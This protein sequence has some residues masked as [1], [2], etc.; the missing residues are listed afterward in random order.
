MVAA[1]RHDGNAG[2]KNLC[3][4]GRARM[5]EGYVNCDFYTCLAIPSNQLHFSPREKVRSFNVI[6]PPFLFL[7]A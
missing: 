3:E 5:K 6:L 2:V 4:N 1:E 7:L